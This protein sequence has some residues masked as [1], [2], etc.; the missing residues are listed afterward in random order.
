MSN[1]KR[2]T[3]VAASVASGALL[4]LLAAVPAGATPQMVSQAKAA[5]FPAQ[6]C[7][8]CHTVAM[9]K[10]EGFKPDELNERGKWLLSEKDKLKATE[11]KPEWLKTYPGGK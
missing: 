10:K 3:V 7:Q 4:S 6:N 1:S 2:V 9:P 11:V 5:G 8:Y